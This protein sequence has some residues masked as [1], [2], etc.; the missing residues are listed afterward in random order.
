MVDIQTISIAIASASVVAGVVYY[1]LQIRHQNLQ[2]QQQTK[3]RQTDLYWRLLSTFNSKEYVEAF[4]K[5]VNLEFKDYNEFAK[6]YGSAFSETPV[7][8]ALGMV[9]NLFEATGSLL[10]RHLIDVETVSHMLPVS[11]TWEKV[12]PIVDGMRKELNVSPLYEWFEYLYDEM[13]KR[14]QQ[15]QQRGAKSG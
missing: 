6:K 8:V 3:M 5:V 1:S 4:L 7:Q 14:E 13:Q 15:L 9:C 12:K 11:Y 2:I 10:Y